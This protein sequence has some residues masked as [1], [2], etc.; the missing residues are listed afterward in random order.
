VESVQ[1]HAFGPPLAGALLAWT[2]VSLR[3]RRLGPPPLPPRALAAAAGALLLY[4]LLRL[5]LQQA[6][7]VPGFPLTPRVPP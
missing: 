1:L 3:Q 7:G 2:A 5:T 4:W 6:F